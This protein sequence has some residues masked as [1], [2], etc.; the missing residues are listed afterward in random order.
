MTSQASKNALSAGP[1]ASAR[2]DLSGRERDKLF[3]SS[4]GAS[5]AELSYLSGADGLEDA[6]TFARA[7]LD[8][9]G[10]EDLVVVNRNAPLLRVYRN[11]LGPARGL[12]FL[13]LSLQGAAPSN[14]DAIGSTVKLRC[15]E[16]QAVRLLAMGE[17]FAATNSLSLTLGLPCEKPSV[18]VTFPSGQQRAFG[19]L[20][21]GHFYRITEGV[22]AQ[23]VPGVYDPSGHPERSRGAGP[24]TAASAP[25]VTPSA[26]PVTPSEVEGRALVDAV[27]RLASPTRGRVLVSLWATWCEACKRDG[28]RVDA[29]AAR[30]GQA[31]DVV[32]LSAEPKDDEAAVAAYRQKVPLAHRLLPF[33]AAAHDATRALFGGEVPGLPA[34]VLI[35]VKARK[36]LWHT[37]GTPTASELAQWLDAPPV[38]PSVAP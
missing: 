1:R 5:F 17:G 30:F 35:D 31:L 18:E 24:A 37:L 11:A 16:R 32:G 36:V 33:D 10:H 23:E 14:R 8:R 4:G 19:S 27:V 38:T 6:R 26:P 29:L 9:D 15:Q 20:L 12:P 22:G 21:P 25:P 28:P 2:M 7:D 13:G 34:T 3:L